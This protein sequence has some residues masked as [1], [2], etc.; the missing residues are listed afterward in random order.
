MF[1]RL[2]LCLLLTTNLCS[3]EPT[4]SD[5]LSPVVIT[6]MVV[7]I[8]VIV[9]DLYV[10]A[11]SDR[12]EKIISGDEKAVGEAINKI[13]TAI[14]ATMGVIAIPQL[15]PISQEIYEYTFPT[16]E[17]KAIQ[18]VKTAAAIENINF[19]DAKVKLRNCLMKSKSDCEKNSSGCPAGCEELA[20]NLI[21]L[22]HQ[23]EV[24]RMIKALNEFGQ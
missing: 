17:Q 11:N 24:D 13:T 23:D 22:G 15:Y 12:L 4:E 9:L 2:S 5:K 16:E 14:A 21:E 10:F 19:I 18:E 20:Q 6:A 3:A 1:K 7:V 8:G